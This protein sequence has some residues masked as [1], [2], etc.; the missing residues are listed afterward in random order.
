MCII[1]ILH[2]CEISKIIN[3]IFILN[4]HHLK[5]KT[6]YSFVF[7]KFKYNF[8]TQFKDNF[9]PEKLARLKKRVNLLIYSF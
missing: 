8:A 2:V 5:Q 3:C 1:A 7:I 6:A 9:N 4:I